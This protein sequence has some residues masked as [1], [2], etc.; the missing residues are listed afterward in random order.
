M[1]HDR[2]HEDKKRREFGNTL[3]LAINIYANVYICLVLERDPTS[4]Q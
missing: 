3:K 4:F 1:L 2:V